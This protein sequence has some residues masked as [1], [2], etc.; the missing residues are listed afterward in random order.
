VSDCTFGAAHPP[1]RTI[2]VIRV[3]VVYGV[4]ACSGRVRPTGHAGCRALPPLC[5][6]GFLQSL[7]TGESSQ[8][9]RSCAVGAHMWYVKHRSDTKVA[10]A[11][12]SRFPLLYA[13][14]V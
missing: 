5:P 14:R 2:V 6:R 7:N 4:D 1:G 13:G 11:A 3:D 9:A 10:V 12:A 8:I